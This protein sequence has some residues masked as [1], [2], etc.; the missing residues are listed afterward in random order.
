[1]KKLNH[2]PKCGKD[3]SI[4]SLTEREKANAVLELAKEQEAER[5]SNP[6]LKAEIVDI[7]DKALA[8]KWRKV[9]ELNESLGL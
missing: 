6:N 8:I 9:D 1:M 5:K 3:E 7:G 2:S 4:V